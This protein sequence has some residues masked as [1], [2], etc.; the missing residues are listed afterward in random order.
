MIPTPV[1]QAIFFTL[2][3]QS[4]QRLAAVGNMTIA[5][6]DSGKKTAVEDGF[7]FTVAVKNHKTFNKDGAAMIHFRDYRLYEAIKKYRQTI[8]KEAM[9]EDKLLHTEVS[10]SVLSN[11]TMYQ[12]M[13]KFVSKCGFV[14]NAKWNS[15]IFRRAVSTIVQ[16]AEDELM[17]SKATTQ[18]SHSKAVA[19]C[20]YKNVKSY[21]MSANDMVHIED[22][23][24][25]RFD[26]L[27]K[28]AEM[29][30]HL[31]TGETSRDNSDIKSTCCLTE[32]V[33]LDK[34]YGSKP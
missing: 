24:K 31:G 33:S 21:E 26:K 20:Y 25:N 30:D 8:R 6:F 18:M 11:A 4:L 1:L 14:F 10:E 15:H 17:L 5:E 22:S 34:G 32:F 12:W 3:L 13:Q 27:M 9:P 23:I 29:Q 2:L 28:S 19:R 7:I 16:D